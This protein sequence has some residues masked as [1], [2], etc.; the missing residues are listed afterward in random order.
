[1]ANTFKKDER[2]NQRLH[3]KELGRTRIL[4]GS[5]DFPLQ[6]LINLPVVSIQNIATF[7]GSKRGSGGYPVII[8]HGLLF[9]QQNTNKNPL[10]V[11][12]LHSSMYPRAP[13]PALEAAL[14]LWL[15]SRASVPSAVLS[16]LPRASASFAETWKN[17]PRPPTKKQSKANKVR[18]ATK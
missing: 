1:M 18:K 15:G 2:I 17:Q 4:Q 10:F 5:L 16:L 8:L 3:C 6:K 7:G 14:E 9:F 12:D 11:Q 13:L